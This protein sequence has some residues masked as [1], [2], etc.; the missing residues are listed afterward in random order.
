[1][2]SSPDSPALGA[3]RIE[4]STVESKLHALVGWAESAGWLVAHPSEQHG[5]VGLLRVLRE[6]AVEIMAVDSHLKEV[7]ASVCKAG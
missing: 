7:R 2:L 5:R 3:P 6:A 1:M 4:T